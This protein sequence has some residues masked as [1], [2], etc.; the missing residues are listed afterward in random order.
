M[1]KAKSATKAGKDNDPLKVS[2]RKAIFANPK[3]TLEQAQEA[4]RKHGDVTVKLVNGVKSGVVRFLGLSSAADLPEA[5]KN[6]TPNLSALLR[7]YVKKHPD[8]STA[9][10]EADFKALGLSVNSVALSTAKKS[11]GHKGKKHA[12]PLSKNAELVLQQYD[13]G[14][15]GPRARKLTKQGRRKVRSAK[16]IQGRQDEAQNWEQMERELDTLI[17]K[18]ENAQQSKLAQSLRNSRR[19]VSA[20]IVQLVT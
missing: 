20:K 5:K 1:S 4:C 16:E 11:L 6:G 2:L 7:L 8:A 18:A 3:L 10:A 13:E 14:P 19:L 12:K 15:Q 9:K 17:G